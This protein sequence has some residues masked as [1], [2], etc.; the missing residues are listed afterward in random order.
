MIFNS[1][2]EPRT[3]SEGGNHLNHHPIINNLIKN[4]FFWCYGQHLL[5]EESTLF[6]DCNCNATKLWYISIPNNNHK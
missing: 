1:V 6:I 5:V 2:T 3:I 4:D